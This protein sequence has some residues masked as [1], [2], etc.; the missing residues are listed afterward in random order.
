ME[1]RTLGHDL[2]V[3]AIGLGCMVFSHGYGDPIDGRK[4]TKLTRYWI[5]FL[6]H[7]FLAALK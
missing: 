1:E 7:K 2:K 5:Q 3:S 6:C 4:L